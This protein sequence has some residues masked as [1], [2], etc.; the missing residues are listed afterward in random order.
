MT[1]FQQKLREAIQIIDRID[2]KKFLSI[3]KRYKV[4]NSRNKEVQEFRSLKEC[5]I[6]IEQKESEVSL[7]RVHAYI[8]GTRDNFF[9]I[10][11]QSNLGEPYKSS[12]TIVRVDV[13]EESSDSETD[14]SDSDNIKKEETK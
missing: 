6:Y 14:S 13:D 1:R 9:D 5:L 3:W 2:I 11:I 12:Y 8:S 4:T 7:S 10:E